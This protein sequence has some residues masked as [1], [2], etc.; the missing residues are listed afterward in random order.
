[1][2]TVYTYKVELICTSVGVSY[3]QLTDYLVRVLA[4]EVRTHLTELSCLLHC[5]GTA[6]PTMQEHTHTH[7]HTHSHI[8]HR[9]C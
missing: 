7:I 3:R 5:G 1:M 8:E 6:K 9:T 2:G 4:K